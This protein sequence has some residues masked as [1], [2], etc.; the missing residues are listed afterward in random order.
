M[1]LIRNLYDYADAQIMA[2]VNA[3]VS[4]WN[5]LTGQTRADLAYHLAINTAPLLP[6]LEGL[7]QNNSQLVLMGMLQTIASY[8]FI[9]H[10]SEKA[11]EEELA[12]KESGPTR[13]FKEETKLANIVGLAMSGLTLLGNQY[14]LVASFGAQTLA[15][16]I[17]RAQPQ[18]YKKNKK[19]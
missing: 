16:Y 3:G 2:H 19:K 13:K 9:V 4:K 1:S 5:D 17:N 12:F 18:I 10:G 8:Y 14:S 15:S 6:A 11:E 7:R